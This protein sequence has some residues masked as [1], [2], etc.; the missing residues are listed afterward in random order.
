MARRRRL[1]VPCVVGAEL[2]VG[3]GGGDVDV[4]VRRGVN[5]VDGV[6]RISG[7][8]LCG[9]SMID[10]VG[11]GRILDRRAVVAR[12][13]SWRRRGVIPGR[14]DVLRI[15]DWAFGISVLREDILELRCSHIVEVVDY[16]LCVSGQAT[17]AIV[18]V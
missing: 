13:I 5:E 16:D 17:G 18:P 1:A 7:P 2:D 4:V 14:D 9:D 6:R 8:S 12:G 3:T 11:D 10:F 15:G